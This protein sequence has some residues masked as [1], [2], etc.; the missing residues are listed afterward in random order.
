[1]MLQHLHKFAGLGLLLAMIIVPIQTA[2]V[3]NVSNLDWNEHSADFLQTH[4]VPTNVFQHSD[5]S[6]V[7][8]NKRL[9][10]VVIDMIRLDYI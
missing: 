3:N 6:T 2:D 4:N 7:K 8:M 10:D 9:R 5:A 1:M